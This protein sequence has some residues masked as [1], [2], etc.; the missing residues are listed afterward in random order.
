MLRSRG[1]GECEIHV[2]PP[3]FAR[4]NKTDI[5]ETAWDKVREKPLYQYVNR[6]NIDNGVFEDNL[7]KMILKNYSLEIFNSKCQPGA[8]GVH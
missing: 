1:Q 4:I 8:M 2:K 3:D 6:N 7:R 5:L